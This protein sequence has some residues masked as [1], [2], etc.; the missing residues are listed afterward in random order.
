MKYETKA[1][2]MIDGR[3]LRFDL[4]LLNLTNIIYFVKHYYGVPAFS[5]IAP[6][7]SVW[8]VAWLARMDGCAGLI[9]NKN[10]ESGK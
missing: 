8:L 2:Y 3:K 6:D 7:F 10:F 5:I 1:I 9:Y 4:T